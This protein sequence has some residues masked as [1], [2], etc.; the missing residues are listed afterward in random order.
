MNLLVQSDFE[1]IRLNLNE[2][3]TTNFLEH[4]LKFLKVPGIPSPPIDFRKQQNKSFRNLGPG[5][6]R[7]CYVYIWFDH[8]Y[9]DCWFVDW[10]GPKS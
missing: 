3:C 6:V 1:P 8:I 10:I 7:V 9:S 2:V 5:K 4:A